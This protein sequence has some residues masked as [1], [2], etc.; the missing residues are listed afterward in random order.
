LNKAATLLWSLL[1]VF[2]LSAIASAQAIQPKKTFV[3]VQQD[4]KLEV[5]DWGGAG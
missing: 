4:L 2:G 3:E 5:L 1:A